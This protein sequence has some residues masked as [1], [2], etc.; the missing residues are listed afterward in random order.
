[1]TRIVSTAEPTTPT[2]N[3]LP[4][5]PVAEILD[6]LCRNPDVESQVRWELPNSGQIYL[7]AGEL[8]DLIRLRQGESATIFGRGAIEL[9]ILQGNDL[10]LAEKSE[11]EEPRVLQFGHLTK[12]AL[13]TKR[14]VFTN[15]S[16]RTIV[17]LDQSAPGSNVEIRYGH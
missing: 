7:C 11:L 3:D 12:L 1:M 2:V 4:E 14:Y 16:S 8:S 5:I 15:R 13:G 17:L 10:E 9:M 6:Q